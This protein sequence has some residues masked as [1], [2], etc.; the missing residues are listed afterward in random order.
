MKISVTLA[1]S[2]LLIGLSGCSTQYGCKGLPEDPA[3]LSAVEAYQITDKANATVRPSDSTTPATGKLGASTS[4]A[5]GS[6]ST[7]EPESGL[8]SSAMINRRTYS[9]PLPK[10]DDPTPIRTPSKVMRIWVAPWEDSDGDLNVSGYLFTELEPRRWMVGKAAPSVATS[11][12]PLQVIHREKDKK[13]IPSNADTATM[14]PTGT[15]DSRPDGMVST[16]LD[17]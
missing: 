14:N 5:Q 13:R 7:L 17:R 4:S 3:C 6:A 9:T 10:I 2:T 1:I 16:P 15:D 8:A 12:K 11:L